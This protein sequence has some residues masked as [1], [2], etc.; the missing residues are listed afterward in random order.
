MKRNGPSSF[1]P[2]ILE[3]RG[4]GIFFV[5]ALCSTFRSVEQ[6]RKIKM[7]TECNLIISWNLKMK[8]WYSFT[9][10]MK[11][12]TKSFKGEF[13]KNS[14]GAEWKHGGIDINRF[15]TRD[16]QIYFFLYRFKFVK[17][18]ENIG[19]RTR[20]IERTIG[21]DIDFCVNCVPLS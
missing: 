14:V 9:F 20:E 18:I 6:Y 5:T 12:E 4:A 11:G 15:V 19:K 8:A 1:Y 10:G 17:R 3:N 13:G 21:N 7:H 2:L 16:G